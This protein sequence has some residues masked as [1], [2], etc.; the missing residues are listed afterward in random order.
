MSI[1][2]LLR[3]AGR[4][5]CKCNVSTLTGKKMMPKEKIPLFE[6]TFMSV[7]GGD[8]LLQLAGRGY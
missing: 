4:S 8:G 3:E 6:V 2:S 5:F 1:L 7:I